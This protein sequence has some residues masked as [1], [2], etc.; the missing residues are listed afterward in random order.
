MDDFVRAGSP[1]YILPESVLFFNQH[2]LDPAD[3]KV[4]FFLRDFGLQGL[5]YLKPFFLFS[6]RDVVLETCGPCPRPGGVNKR[7]AHVKSDFLQK[8]QGLLE[9]LPGFAGKTDDEIGGKG[10][11]R[12]CLTHLVDD[13]EIIP[14]RVTPPHRL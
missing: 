8:I 9:F 6:Q 5:Q 12:P 4:I 10:N 11:P 2:F 1:A 3:Q 7:I 14:T 13:F